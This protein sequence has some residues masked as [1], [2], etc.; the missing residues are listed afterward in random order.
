MTDHPSIRPSGIADSALQLFREVVFHRV[1]MWDALSSLERE[2]N[3]EITDSEH[4]TEAFA[5]SASTP[6]DAHAITRE[7]MASAFSSH[8]T[9]IISDPTLPPLSIND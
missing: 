4:L 5:S 9:R 1:S 2:L 6:E 8:N 7:A 3:I